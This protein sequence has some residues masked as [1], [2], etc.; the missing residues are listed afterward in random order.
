MEALP[1][2]IYRNDDAIYLN[3]ELLDAL[4]ENLYIPPHALRVLLSTFCG[5]FDLLLYLIRRQRF[6]VLDLPMQ[7][8][9]TQ[10]FHYMR[11]MQKED[12]PL[13]GEYLSM[14]AWLC[15]I[16]SRLLLPASA[17]VEAEE[18]PRQDLSQRLQAYMKIQNLAHALDKLPRLQ[19]DFFIPHIDGDESL[20]ALPPP[21]PQWSDLQAIMRELILR[22]KLSRE[23]E[24]KREPY[25]LDERMDALLRQSLAGGWHNWRPV[26]RTWDDK[27]RLIVDFLALL[28]LSKRGAIDLEQQGALLRYRRRLTA[29]A[30]A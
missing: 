20:R 9:T 8:I 11:L 28:I 30:V 17:D 29:E 26:F 16:K 24:I 18:D 22:R 10:Y 3:G 6:N 19:R 4:P 15:E 1:A 5:P 27:Q 21:C 12:L 23:H 7:T 13:A 14:A 25:R 2:V